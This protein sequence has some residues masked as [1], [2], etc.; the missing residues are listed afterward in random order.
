MQVTSTSRR[1]GLE[2]GNSSK[3]AGAG[4]VGFDLSALLGNA[5]IKGRSRK[6]NK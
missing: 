2:S 3:G 5:L 4:A 1:D 6:L